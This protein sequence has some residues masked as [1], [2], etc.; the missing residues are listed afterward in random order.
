MRCMI[1]YMDFMKAFDKV[2]HRRLIVKLRA[3]GM[4][5]KMCNSAVNFLYDR[6]QRVQ[7]NGHFSEWAKVTSGIPQG[8]VLGPVLFVIYIND[9]PDSVISEIALYADD[10][11]LSK[12]IQSDSDVIVVQDGL[13]ILQDWS[14][15]WLLLF[16]PDKCIVIR[17]CLPWKCNID[18]PEYFMRKS[19]SSEVKLEVS[20]CEKDIGVYIDE[21][22]TFETHIVTKVNKANSVMG[23]IRRSFT[24]LDEELFVLLFRALVHPILEY[25]Q[26][27]WS[28]YLKKK[29]TAK[30][31]RYD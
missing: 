16:H 21:H 14:D 7:V 25:A 17:I 18:K 8:S 19:D 23:I 1:V 10:T 29:T 27:V 20:S 12:E 31:Y 22:L 15:D 6:R 5:E 3:Y 26:S 2:S 30:T 13:F 9:L 11:K 28:P 24:F 4:S